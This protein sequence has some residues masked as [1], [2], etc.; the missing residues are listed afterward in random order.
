MVLSPPGITSA[1]TVRDIVVAG[2]A[3]NMVVLGTVVDGTVTVNAAKSQ[4]VA[5]ASVTAAIV[6][7]D[8]VV[9]AAVG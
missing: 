2:L 6:L 7:R 5:D 3:R 1:C 4:Q 9:A 8:P